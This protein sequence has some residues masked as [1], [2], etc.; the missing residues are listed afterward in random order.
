MINQI[1]GKLQER[2]YP[3]HFRLGETTMMGWAKRL[4]R[5]GEKKVG[6]ICGWAKRPESN[7]IMETKNRSLV[8]IG[9]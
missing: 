9:F 6:R 2:S 3:C 5:L 4:N 7:L 8:F 1:M